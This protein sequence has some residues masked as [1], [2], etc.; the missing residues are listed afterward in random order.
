MTNTSVRVR[1]APSPTGFMHLGNVRAALINYIFA[2]H[3]K[4]TF[5]LRIED[6]D[7]ERNFDP[8][9]HHIKDDLAWL[10]LTYTEGPDIGGPH[11]PYFQSQRTNIYAHELE[12]LKNNRLIYR[13]FC[14][15]EEL[16]KKRQ[17]QLALKQAPRYDRTCFRLSP[18][19]VEERLTRNMPFMWR[20][21]LD[22]KETVQIYDLAR[23]EVTF[24]MCN[25]SDFALTR[26]DGSFT[27]IFANFV[28]DMLMRI[29]HI[30]RGED[31]LTNTACQAVLY[32]AYKRELPIFW[33]LPIITNREGKKLSK[34][35]F[36][37]SLSDLRAEGFLPEAIV[38]YLAI[39]GSSFKQEIMDMFT[40]IRTFNFQHIHAAGQIQYDVEK[41]LW[42]NHQWI[43]QYPLHQLVQLCKPFLEEAYPEAKKLSAEKL[44]QLVRIVTGELKTVRHIIPTTRFYFVRPVHTLEQFLEHM[45]HDTY[46]LLKRIVRDCQA[47]SDN[48]EAFIAK[49]QADA[50]QHTIAPKKLF[51]FLRLALAGT[52]QGPQV[53]DI[54]LLLGD[55]EVQ[56]R[57]AAV[58]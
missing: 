56:L 36:G 12:Y 28:D 39:I 9:A 6:T 13:C 55:I 16:E 33:H 42:V 48:P 11:A 41:L 40:L 22:P 46:L 37:F 4:G 38:N 17:R 26:P 14:T 1:F 43:L 57:L 53:K 2:Q 5:I 58:P 47:L 8:H 31:H 50:Q 15:A 23:G 25:F 27:F 49:A 24:E 54:L 18:Q 3:K 32:R 35:D 44:D 52:L 7:P 34:R 29:S 19:G 51:T 10:G 20:F 45:S 21:A 30:F